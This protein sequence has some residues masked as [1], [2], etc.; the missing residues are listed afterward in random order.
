MDKA[1][2]EAAVRELLLALDQNVESEGL[3]DTPR[4]VADMFIEQ[5]VGDGEA[6][7]DRVFST[8]SFDGMV[9]VRDM[10]F[11]S[12]CMHHLVF[13]SGRAHIAYIPKG[14]ALGLSK[15]S[16]LVNYCSRGFTI[17]EDVTELIASTLYKEVDSLGCM[18]VTEAEH[19]CMCLR[20][21]RAIGSSTVVSVVKGVFRDVTA[22]RTEFLSLIAKGGPR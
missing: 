5:V 16:R 15:L 17:Q 10:P 14:P 4:R 11:V 3:R 9:I 7:L 6:E 2:A 12:C 19:G 1:K 21:A 20:G 13:Y 8:A 18:V 22:A